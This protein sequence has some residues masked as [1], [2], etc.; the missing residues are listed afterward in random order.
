MLLQRFRKHD[1]A[2][3]GRLFDFATLKEALVGRILLDIGRIALLQGVHVSMYFRHLVRGLG[4]ITGPF[5]TS[6]G[7]RYRWHMTVFGH[8]DSPN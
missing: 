4:I 5:V 7:R 3:A 1:T 8:L 6:I 2:S